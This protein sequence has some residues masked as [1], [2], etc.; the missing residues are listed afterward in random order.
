MTRRLK[1]YILC[2]PLMKNTSALA[3]FANL[4][5][6]NVSTFYSSYVHFID[7]KIFSG[8]EKIRKDKYPTGL[9]PDSQLLFFFL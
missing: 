6:R 3:K 9:M 1:K 7:L 4:E 8:L 5:I 2:N